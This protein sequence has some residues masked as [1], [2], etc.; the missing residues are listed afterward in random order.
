MTDRGVVGRVAEASFD[1]DVWRR[2]TG[3]AMYD[4]WLFACARNS[5]RFNELYLDGVFSASLDP[6]APASTI[7]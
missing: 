2:D 7:S 5:L 1:E 6:P 3:L 4:I